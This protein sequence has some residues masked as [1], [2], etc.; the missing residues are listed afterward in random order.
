MKLEYEVKFSKRKRLNITIERDRRIVVRAP[1]N[2]PMEKVDKIV[3]SKKQWIRE[4]L[5]HSQK[6]PAEITPKEFVT[7]ETLMYL[8][9]NYQLVV[10]DE[11]FDGIKFK[12]RFHISRSNQKKANQLFKEWYR[13][14][15]LRKLTKLADKYAVNLGVE[16]NQCK[17]SSMKYRWAS[18]TPTNNLIF[19][20]RI[21]K[22][23]MYV[24]EYL[25]VHELTHLIEHNHTTKFW[26]IV[27]VQVPN[28]QKAKTWLK[29][30]GQQLEIDF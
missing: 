4:K 8:G 1:V 18:C 29:E 26:N 27:S 19:N 20:W 3:Q 23:P 12:S 7:G 25:V 2:T 17:V 6:Y 9:R 21:I 5:G 11:E 22:A 13:G 24:L 14:K 30:H 15:A 10:E 28:F 16:F